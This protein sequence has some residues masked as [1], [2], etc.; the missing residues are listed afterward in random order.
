MKRRKDVPGR[1]NIIVGCLRV[2]QLLGGGEAGRVPGRIHLSLKKNQ[3]NSGS[4]C[5]SVQDVRLS[6]SLP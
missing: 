3:G 2:A 4:G 5:T 6:P 1:G